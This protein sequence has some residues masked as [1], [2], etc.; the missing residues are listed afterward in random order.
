MMTLNEHQWR[1]D[2]ADIVSA[3]ERDPS[4]FLR[5]LASLRPT[6]HADA[7]CAGEPV[8]LFFPAAG[9]PNQPGIDICGRCPVRRQ[10]LKWAIDNDI[11]FGIWGGMSTPARKA[12]QRA[13]RA[14]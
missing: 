12:H 13:R 9:H 1:G 11:R 14:A 2:P 3:A 7:L 6:W 10:C 4:G 8:G 5:R